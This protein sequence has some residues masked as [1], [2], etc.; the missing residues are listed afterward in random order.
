MRPD[1]ITADIIK[2]ILDARSKY[3]TKINWQLVDCK[4]NVQ[5]YTDNLSINLSQ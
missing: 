3:E 1:N 2:S 4:Q 5:A